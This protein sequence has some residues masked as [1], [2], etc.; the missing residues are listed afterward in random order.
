M[1]KP[2]DQVEVVE[3]A[4]ED[5]ADEYPVWAGPGWY[6]GVYISNENDYWN[7]YNQHYQNR[8]GNRPD[9]GRQKQRTL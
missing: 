7:H 3:D 6:W 9:D 1:S 4:N 5:E 2:A 8:Q